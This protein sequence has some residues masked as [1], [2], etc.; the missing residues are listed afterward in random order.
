MTIQDI[1][2]H[3]T[4]KDL[5]IAEDRCNTKEYAE[6]VID[7][8]ALPEWQTLLQSLLG[9]PISAQG[10]KPSAESLAL[11]EEYGG[12]WVDQVLYKCDTIESGILMAMLW[13]W[14]SA[15]FITIKIAQ[16]I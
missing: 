14:E 15:L 6:F 13:P 11:T 10:E 8:D 7:N 4:K 9:E 2:D 16:I 3:A 1:I 12:L 5:R